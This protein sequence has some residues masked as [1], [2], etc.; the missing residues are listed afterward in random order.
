VVTGANL[1]R[2]VDFESLGPLP[3]RWWRYYNSA[4]NTVRCSLGWG[5]AHE[6]ECVL[7]LDLDGVSY[8]DPS[9]TSFGFPALEPGEAAAQDGL[10]LRRLDDRR[11]EVEEHE[12]PI[13]VFEF[14]PDCETAPLQAVY[15]GPDRITFR[16]TDDG[17]LCEIVGSNERSIRVECD[18]AGYVRGLFLADG[19]G[20]GEERPL[21][22]YDYDPAG[23]LVLGRDFAGGT[24]TFRYDAA[25]RMTCRTDRRNYSF[26]FRYD[27]QGRCVYSA[28]D[29]G[30]LEV[31]LEFEPE[32]GATFVTRADGGRWGYFH[33][34][35]IITRIVD[36]Y[37]GATRFRLD[38]TGRVVEEIDPCGHVTKL[39][40]DAR[41]RHDR[42]I[43][44]LG[45]E[46]PPEVVDPDLP[47]FVA[48]P[49]PATP[50]GWE[51]GG[52]VEP[53]SI[54][55]PTTDDP[56]LSMFPAA[57]FNTV[58]NFTPAYE[59][60]AAGDGQGGPTDARRLNTLQ[61]APDEAMPTHTE[62]REYDANGNEVL[63]QDRE[64]S[65]VR[66]TYT[67][68]NL[69]QSRMDPEGG[70]TSFAYSPQGL[71]T[72]IQDPG[73]SVH[74]FAYDLKD[75][76]A[77]VR[78]QGIVRERHRYD[79]ASNRIETTDS[80]GHAQV[81]CEIGPGKA[82]LLR[83]LRSGEVH[84]FEYASRGRLESASTPDCTVGLKYDVANRLLRDQRD[85]QGVTHEFDR[86][87]LVATTWFGS[88]RTTY[89]TDGSA[90]LVV[91]PTGAV[92][93]LEISPNGLLARV[94]ANGTAELCQYDA[95][96]RCRRKA[97]VRGGST[98]PWL[99]TY[100][101]SAAGDL[102]TATDTGAGVTRYGYDAAHRLVEEVLPGGVSR[103]YQHD[104]AG[105]LL[106]QPGLTDVV[107]D[108][109]NRLRAANGARFT[110]NE[111]DQV[112]GREGPAGTV[113]YQ[114]DDLGRL[115][116]C[117]VDGEPWTAGYDALGRRTHKTW[118]G[119][120]TTFYPDGERP[121]AVVGAD[122][123]LRLYLYPDQTALVPF[124]FVEYDS[125]EAEPAS[126]RRYYI[127][128]NHIGAPIRVEDDAGRK[129]WGA[130]VD[131]Y[132][133]A[134]IDEDATIEL[135]LRFPGHYH[136][137]ETDLHYN[138]FRYYSPELGRYLQVDPLGLDG[139]LNLYAYVSSPLTTVDL[140]GRIGAG[141]VVL[142]CGTVVNKGTGP[143]EWKPNDGV[144]EGE[145]GT[146]KD[147]V[148]KG[149]VG[150]G[151]TPDHIPSAAALR[152]AEEQRLGRPLT[153]A[154]A[155]AVT[156]NGLCI[157]VGKDIHAAGDTYK[158]K[159]TAA[160]I[161]SDSTNLGTAAQRDLNTHLNNA[162]DPSFGR[163][164][165]EQNNIG[166]GAAN[167]DAAN[168]AKGVY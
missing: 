79:A 42:R 85:G 131:P 15:F 10:L 7:Q 16:Y 135:P 45:R 24:L 127:F 3:L 118:R 163:S 35:G 141:Q 4:R 91:D 149:K 103:A 41:G 153:P 88:F 150:D 154:E 5:H 124:L 62:R 122:G 44:P 12:Q 159:N 157:M 39:L 51:Q 19:Q 130:R 93:R 52:L 78:R 107:V 47:D 116:R 74:D 162:V 140:D 72:H 102:R 160:Q 168:R 81:T 67:S 125:L 152:A 1:D 123:S 9:G 29:D 106:R 33:T 165:T 65:V 89:R 145:V 61:R 56:V 23:N 110:Y 70:V 49:L 111:R 161:A 54:N 68:W 136:D 63:H 25:N 143:G 80:A 31:R 151:L 95:R 53:E 50:L 132:G 26:H 76:L 104:A 6:Y 121:G 48:A 86:G 38:D 66:T 108:P 112:T 115:V 71:P 64:G 113:R 133:R 120:T 75:R 98:S 83:R 40:Y 13:R 167:L 90:R 60:G 117:D 32:I 119:Q 57:V 8:T 148:A 30:L 20:P 73:G 166:D 59:H 2:S 46:F 92:H 87:R 96:G 18:A 17:R 37:G 97:A 144:Q 99:R 142:P 126:G 82:S 164:T 114:Y 69:V 14:A 158:G 36:P 101:Y 129:V 105:N 58:L 21:M 134:T 22:V 34:D 43:D 128:T 139:G 27:D 146:Y 55:R 147:L 109:G 77:E 94:L 11:Y 137:P 155:K 84:G 100:H 28:G 156:D 138:R